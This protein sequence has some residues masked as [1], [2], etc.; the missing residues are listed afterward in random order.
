[1]D[2]NHIRESQV[3][4]SGV[5]SRLFTLNLYLLPLSGGRA[6]WD[7]EV[8]STDGKSQKGTCHKVRRGTSRVEV[9]GEL[10]K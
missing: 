5:E 10:K 7:F 8:E 9:L 3:V 6:E 4:L 1:M 2:S